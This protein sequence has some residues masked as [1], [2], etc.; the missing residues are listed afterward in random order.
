MYEV[1]DGT[2]NRGGNL[3][4]SRRK[5][6]DI[7]NRQGGIGKEPKRVNKPIIGPPKPVSIFRMGEGR[8]LDQHF[9]W[10]DD[11]GFENNT[12]LSP[13][14][15]AQINPYARQDGKKNSKK[16]GMN[17]AMRNGTFPSG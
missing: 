8:N 2:L 6:N 10:M 15:A 12:K 13:E 1:P 17:S 11:K 4:L 16:Q 3:P 14:L 9:S 7:M 5:S